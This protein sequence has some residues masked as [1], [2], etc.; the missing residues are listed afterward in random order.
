MRGRNIRTRAGWGEGEA[1]MTTWPSELASGDGEARR[2][3]GV[4]QA[5]ST[6]C[7]GGTRS[8]MATGEDGG[9]GS[10]GAELRLE[11]A[12]AFGLYTPRGL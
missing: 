2:R 12:E 5:P 1:E 9:F 4:V 7:G 10:G 11:D 3:V 8:G 6:A